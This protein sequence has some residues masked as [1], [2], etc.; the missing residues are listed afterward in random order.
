MSFENENNSMNG[1]NPDSNDIENHSA[2]PT[3][4]VNFV[5]KEGNSYSNGNGNQ[6]PGQ[7]HANTCSQPQSQPVYSGP[8][9]SNENAYY[10]GQVGGGY[11]GGNGGNGGNGGHISHPDNGRGNHSQD[12]HFKKNGKAKNIAKKAGWVTAAAILFGVVSGGTI[13]GV[14]ALSDSFLAQQATE[15]SETE[16]VEPQTS[17]STEASAQ[18]AETAEGDSQVIA[19]DVSG[20]VDEVMPSMVSISNTMLYS[21]NSWFYGNQTYEVPSSGSGIIL[22]ENDTE[23]L[24]VTNNHV[25]EDSEELSVT[26][27]D[28]T[29]AEAAIKGTDSTADLAVVAVPLDSIPD[30]TKS[31]IKPAVLGDSSEVK[32]GQ[33]VIAI[34]NALGYGQSVTVGYVS[35]VDRTIQIDESGNTK[36]VIQTD[37]AINPGNSGG[38]LINMKGE[39]IGINEA[40]TSATSVEGVGYAIPV[41]EVQDIITDLMNSKTRITVDESKQGYLGIQGTDVSERDSSLYGMPIGVYVYK[42]VEGGA[43]SQSDLQEKDII[44]KIDGQSIASM[45]ELKEMLTYYEEGTQVTLTVQRLENGEYTEKQVVVTLGQKP[46]EEETEAQ[47]QPQQNMPRLFQ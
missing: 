25:I 10:N 6:Q 12:P 21:T 3:E 46:E 7:D 20:I 36:N 43:A 8:Y 16:R 38:A 34:G 37:A 33:G 40:K 19:M 45:E 29:T 24:I 35:A 47:P 28:G 41:S 13:V 42:L 14:N 22:G 15:A 32:M 9:Q 27:I 30:D 44:T 1:M 23:L 4:S 18:P 5:M 17:S 11:Y 39:V 31:K 26:F 2:Q